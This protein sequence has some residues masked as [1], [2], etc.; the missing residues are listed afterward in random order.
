MLVLPA[1]PRACLLQA[2]MNGTVIWKCVELDSLCQAQVVESFNKWINVRFKLWRTFSSYAA[3]CKQ[4]MRFGISS[5]SVSCCFS[6]KN[7]RRLFKCNKK[8][9]TLVKREGKGMGIYHSCHHK[10]TT[11]A[12]LVPRDI[13]HCGHFQSKHL[14][15]G[16]DNL[17]CSLLMLFVL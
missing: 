13:W 17:F 14:R 6:C 5:S 7:Y 10:V 3:V 4:L 2:K 16:S 11:Y 15:G 12:V 8:V 9:F 1:K